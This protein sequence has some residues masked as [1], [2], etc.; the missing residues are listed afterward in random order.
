MSLFWFIEFVLGF[1]NFHIIHNIDIDQ[2][3]GF[4]I[5]LYKTYEIV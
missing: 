1:K 3:F 5:N 2:N 4:Q